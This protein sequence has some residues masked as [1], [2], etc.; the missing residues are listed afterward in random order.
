MSL[1]DFIDDGYDQGGSALSDLYSARNY[2]Y[3]AGNHIANEEWASAKSALYSAGDLF[4]SGF[5]DLLS[6]TVH[7]KGLRRHWYDALYWIDDNWPTTPE[8]PEITMDALLSAMV[9]ATDSQLMSFIGLVDAYRQSLWNKDFN[10]DLFA[11]LARGF[12]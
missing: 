6:D 2:L 11:A 9:T 4:G 3:Y 1:Q 5:A 7:N 8:V 12:E 10:V